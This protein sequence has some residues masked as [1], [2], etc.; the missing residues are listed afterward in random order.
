MDDFI[1]VYPNAVDPAACRQIVDRFEASGH[2]V[3]G[4]TGGGVAPL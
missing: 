3:R 2:A 4:R 1:E